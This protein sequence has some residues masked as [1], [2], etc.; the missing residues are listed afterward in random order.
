MRRHRALPAQSGCKKAPIIRFRIFPPHQ[1]PVSPYITG[2]W[3][4]KV[5]S[6]AGALANLSPDLGKDASCTEHSTARKH[7]LVCRH[8]LRS[9]TPTLGCNTA[10][11]PVPNFAVEQKPVTGEEGSITVCKAGTGR[12]GRGP[13]SM[14]SEAHRYLNNT[15]TKNNHCHRRFKKILI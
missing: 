3:K 11:F 1:G 12:E 10:N 5:V 9:Y 7:A 6:Q 15:A 2:S 13:H 14:I 8:M 4:S